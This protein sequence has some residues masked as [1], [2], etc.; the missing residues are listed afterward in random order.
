MGRWS[1]HVS[2]AHR[3]AKTPLATAILENGAD[4]FELTCLESN[5]PE[6]QMDEREA[7]WI[8]HYKSTT[9]NGYNVMKHSRCKHRETSSIAK[10][11]IPTTTKVR[12]STVK[13]KGEPKIVYVYLDQ[14]N[15][16]PTV[17]LV[18]GQGADAT[19]EEAL[20]EAQEFAGH[21][22]EHG[23]DICEEE[24][25]DV[26]RKYRDKINSLD[27]NKIE[28]IRIAKFNELVALYIKHNEGTLRICFGG[29]IVTFDDAYK[30]AQSVKNAIVE[31]HNNDNIILQDDISKSATG[32][33]S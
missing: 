7:H 24:K 1:D 12:I 18:F 3:V 25:D 9:P 31:T 5:V 4:D 14:S 33:C 10:H 23:L 17:R 16:N 27:G 11:Y 20:A 22:V 28:R 21:F 26:L 29:K 19:Y 13:R 2:S 8:A 6:S 32:G 15:E 30:I